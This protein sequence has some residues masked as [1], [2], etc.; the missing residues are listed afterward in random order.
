MFEELNYSRRHFLS[1]AAVTIAAGPLCMIGSADA[2]PAR[3]NPCKNKS[4]HDKER[5][6]NIRRH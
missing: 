2:Q 4:R 5:C 6:Y 1:A 3:I